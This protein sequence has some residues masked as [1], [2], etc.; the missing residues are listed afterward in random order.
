MRAGR[1]PTGAALSLIVLCGVLGVADQ[2][3]ADSTGVWGTVAGGAGTSAESPTHKIS[4]TLGQWAAGRG[5]ASNRQLEIGFWSGGACDC[6]FHGDVDADG[7]LDIFDVIG[8]V[9]AAFRGLPDPPADALCPHVNRGDVNCDGMINVLDV[10]L[11]VAAAFR[12]DNRL[13]NPCAH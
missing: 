12:N 11:E 5:Q 1:L 7:D 4:G 8:I 2:S 10:V 9:N 6:R 13:C 3:Q